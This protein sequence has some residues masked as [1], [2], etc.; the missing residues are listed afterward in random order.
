MSVF[1]VGL[2][3]MAMSA[4]FE[5]Y[6]PLLNNVSIPAPSSISNDVFSSPRI[7]VWPD[8]N[9]RRLFIAFGCMTSDGYVLAVRADGAG[10]RIDLKRG[11]LE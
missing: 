11:L 5:S 9:L 1:T 6:I 4:E 2:G 3:P 10:V 8:D 7:G